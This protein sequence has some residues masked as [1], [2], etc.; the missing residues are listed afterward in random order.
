MCAMRFCDSFDHYA[1][2]DLTEKWTTLANA[3]IS[4]GTGR[5]GTDSYRSQ[6]ITLNSRLD[7]TLDAQQTWII[8]VAFRIDGSLPGG[9]R[10]LLG[11]LDS[12][13]IQTD[14]RLNSDGTLSLTRNGTALGTSTFALSPNVFYFLELKVFIHDTLGTA[15]VRVNG[16][17]KLTLSG[18][19][20]KN[21]ANA[22]ANVIRLGP[23]LGPGSDWHYDDLYICDGTGDECNDFL[24]DVRV[25]AVP[26]LLSGTV[27]NFSPSSAGAT[28]V[29]MVNQSTP[30]DNTT[31]LYA[32]SVDA[33][34]R[35]VMSNLASVGGS[36]YGVQ[37]CQS[38]AKSDA[39]AR[40]VGAVVLTGGTSALGSAY[41][42]G[43]SY[44][45]LL[46]PLSAAPDGASWTAA[47]LSATEFGLAVVA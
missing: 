39:G 47:V 9:T 33:L 20:T 19:D 25:D 17:P 3:I 10:T 44:A 30:D 18:V 46:T 43:V 4:S 11:T 34:Q 42:P 14:L 23:H 24:G 37:L 27:S 21:T 15:E 36:I 29:S 41:S 31:Y 13:S 40:S 35:F 1:T 28:A 6:T 45:Y 7:L 38:L 16:D 2:G 12:T 8:G 26:V 32:S 22:S 5:R